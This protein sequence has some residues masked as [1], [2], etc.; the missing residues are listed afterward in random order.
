MEL[1][2]ETSSNVFRVIDVLFDIRF[3]EMMSLKYNPRDQ[4]LY[5]WDNGHQVVYD[6]TF[7]P[8][9]PRAQAR[10]QLLPT[11]TNIPFNLQ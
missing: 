9:E 7:D 11:D 3:G 10:S 1:V 6:L 4:K 8:P 2:Y 5:G